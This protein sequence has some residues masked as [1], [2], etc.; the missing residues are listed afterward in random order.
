MYIVRKIDFNC[1]SGLLQ[2]AEITTFGVNSAH[3]NLN[4]E[5]VQA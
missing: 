4:N 2:G 5:R 1:H 3:P